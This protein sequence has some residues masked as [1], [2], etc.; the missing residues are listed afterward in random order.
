MRVVAAAAAVNVLSY[1]DRVCISLVAP[2]LQADLHFGP[3]QMGIIFGAFSLAYALF[4]A[5]WGAIADKRGARRIVAI[6]ILA[7]STCT[8]LTAVA[9]NF[10]SMIAIRFLFGFSEAAIS[11]TVASGFRRVVP[12]SRRSTAFGFFLAG[13]RVGGALAPYITLFV[14]LRY[15][16]RAVFVVLAATGVLAVLVWLAAVPQELDRYETEGGSSGYS[17]HKVLCIPLFALLAVSFSYTMM[18]QFY[19]TW[20]PTYLVQSRGFSMQLVARYAGLPFLL[21][22][23]SSWAGGVLSDVMARWFGPRIGRR[24]FGVGILLTS[25]SCLYLGAVVRD[26]S[27]AAVLIALAAGVGDLLLG[28]SW[29]LAVEIGGKAAGAAAGLFNSASNLGAFVSPIAMGW[30]LQSTGNWDL[31]LR[32]AALCNIVAAVFW[33][34]VVR[35]KAPAP[36]FNRAGLP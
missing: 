9:W 15:G 8:G 16:W 4:Q 12:V 1:V 29:A 19:V 23:F 5:P 13:G 24:L 31:I 32:L 35:R 26:R 3:A 25:A 18:W 30:V 33:V 20:F 34:A 7:W 14:A 6:A 21:G 10:L 28:T 22:L 2:R 27:M 36:S 17:L 11:P